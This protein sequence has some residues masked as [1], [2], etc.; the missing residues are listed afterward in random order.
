[1]IAVG[2]VVALAVL[3]Q[4]AGG[5][6]AAPDP[7]PAPPAS[8]TAHLAGGWSVER[9]WLVDLMADP[10]TLPVMRRHIPWIVDQIEFGTGIQV[11]L[12]FTLADFL[13]VP[14]SQVTP[15]ILAAIQKDLDGVNAAAGASAGPRGP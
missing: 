2:Q 4:G 12:D 11:P 1:M 14:Q 5:S 6:P 10:A 3:A 13:H 7:A 15:E 9:S 8:E